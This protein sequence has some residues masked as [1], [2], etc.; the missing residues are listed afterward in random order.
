VETP[1]GGGLK[2]LAIAVLSSATSL[3]ASA[4]DPISYLNEQPELQMWSYPAGSANGAGS[5]RDRGPTFGAYSGRDD[6]GT[7]VFFP[8]S[9][10]DP[11]RRGSV[12][13]AGDTSLAIETG[14]DP[15]R[16]QI[17]SLRVTATLLGNLINENFG[18]TLPYDNTLDDALSLT[19][20]GGDDA[21]HPIEMYGIGL[22]GDYETISFETGGVEDALQLGGARWRTYR[23][24]EDGYD[25]EL[26][27]NEQAFAPYQYYARDL[28]GNDAENSVFGGY[29]A[30][31]ASGVTDQFTPDPFAIGRLFGEQGS[32][33]APGTLT[34]NGDVYVFEPNLEDPRVVEY[35]Q[36][37]LSEGHL[38]FSFSSMHQPAG[39][40][41]TVAYPD[42][43]LDDLDVGPN[44]DGAAPTIELVVSI[45]D[46]PLPGD[47]D[48]DGDVDDAD[49][50]VWTAQYGSAGSAADGNGDGVVDGADYTLW[51]DNYGAGVA[52]VAVP[53]PGSVGLL[54][55]AGATAV[56]CGFV[57]WFTG[58]S[59]KEEFD[60]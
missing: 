48:A 54:A 40:T 29:S 30:T 50:G 11:S 4:S 38:G 33:Y 45:L 31:E 26:P 8:G 56:F 15:T 24:G 34:N 20:G 19:T 59:R 41:G 9:G 18:L 53:E 22:R 52:S 39:H 16:Y 12:W 32:E 17:E 2:Y 25:P 37:S 46:P 6:T 43:Y 51:R 47:F 10:L 28:N 42:F 7:P 36:T 35:V 27:P 58:P 23:E 57:R 60:D 1:I 3:I 49:Y 44:P 21:G 5:V 14:L 13:V 55:M